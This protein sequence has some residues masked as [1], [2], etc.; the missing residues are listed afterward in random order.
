MAV[1]API[2]QAHG[3]F[4][5]KNKVL[6]FSVK[7]AAGAVVDITGWAITW[8]LWEKDSTP[9]TA[10]VEKTVGDG[11]SIVDGPEGVFQ[12]SIEPDDTSDMAP[13]EYYHEARRTD[14]GYVDVLASGPFWLN[15][16]PST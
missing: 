7:D 14:T 1:L 12:V 13:K 5:G 8:G 11:V 3:V 16:S 4:R 15:Q 10:K 2:Q 6:Q 9:T